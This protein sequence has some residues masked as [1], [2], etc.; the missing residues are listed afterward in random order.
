MP[1]WRGRMAPRSTWRT[2]L[3]DLVEI[4]R[5]VRAG[6]KVVAIDLKVEGR[7]ADKS[8]FT[9][10]GHDLRLGQ[11]VTNLIENARSFVPETGGRIT[12]RLARHR[13]AVRVLVEDN[14]PGIRAEVIERVFERFYTDRP[15]WRGFWPELRS[16]PVD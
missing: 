15:R 6:S 4:A 13:G 10:V 8:K 12:V 9:I 3:T 7:T 1:N 11:V 16:R 14:G 2:L 5:Q